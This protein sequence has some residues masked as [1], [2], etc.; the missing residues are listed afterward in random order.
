MCKW[1]A[2]EYLN[3]GLQHS[4]NLTNQN[5]AHS[6]PELRGWCAVH[7]YFNSRPLRLIYVWYLSKR[8]KTESPRPIIRQTEN[9]RW[10]VCQ[11]CFLGCKCLP[12]FFMC[13]YIC[14]NK[15]TKSFSVHGTIC[16]MCVWLGGGRCLKLQDNVFCS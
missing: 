4:L 6:G 13:I 15:Q 10:S 5:W 14:M 3:Y 11:V 8:N 1:W 2:N 7:S 16:T 9:G 12:V